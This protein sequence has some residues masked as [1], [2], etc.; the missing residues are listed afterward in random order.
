MDRNCSITYRRE[1]K[2]LGSL[3]LVV[4]GGV[5][6]VV[7][8]VVVMVV[9]VV[10][11]AVAVLVGFVT[12]VGLGLSACTALLVGETSACTLVPQASEKLHLFAL[13]LDWQRG[14]KRFH[15]SSQI[16]CFFFKALNFL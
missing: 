8:V 12:Q 14:L 4:G 1:R 2:E 15:V 11:I 7:V 6:V 16:L 13:V 3:E 9:V 5:V 10:V